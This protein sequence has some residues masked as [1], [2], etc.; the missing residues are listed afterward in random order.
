MSRQQRS[1]L[2]ALLGWLGVGALLLGGGFAVGWAAHEIARPV[3]TE[4]EVA[5][6]LTQ[7]EEGRVGSTIT[8]GASVQWDEAPLPASQAAGILTDLPAEPVQVAEGDVLYTVSLRPVVLGDGEIPMFRDLGADARGQDVTQ[9]QSMLSR[10]GYYSGASDGVLGA[11][12]A[13]AIRLWQDSLGLEDDGIVRAGDVVFLPG[14]R[15]TV[16]AAEERRVGDQLSGGEAVLT[17]LSDVPRVALSLT[18]SQQT[19]VAAGMRVS[20]PRPDG[21]GT[22]EGSVGQTLP[23]SQQGGVQVELIDDAEAPLCGSECAQLGGAGTLLVSIHQIEPVSGLTVPASA[24]SIDASG[25]AFLEREDG[26]NVQ[27]DVLASADGIAVIS[28]EGVAA[29]DTVRI[30]DR[31][32]AQ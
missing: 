9:L 24:I 15:A 16:T 17:Q 18:E 32:E 28:G 12:T 4:T 8:L 26:Q 2:R 30:P 21:Q 27:V 10:L 3:A 25:A 13:R 23:A 31:G 5:P 20:A 6:T 29:G 7:I 1:R 11:D 14:G 22:W 19:L